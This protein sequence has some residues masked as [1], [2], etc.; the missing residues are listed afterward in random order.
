[1]H[2]WCLYFTF[3]R[4][5]LNCA[6]G[7]SIS[8]TTRDSFFI[9]MSKYEPCQWKFEPCQILAGI[10]CWPTA[11]CVCSDSQTPP[12]PQESPS[13][14]Q[15]SLWGPCHFGWIGT[16][17][18]LLKWLPRPWWADACFPL[19]WVDMIHS[20]SLLAVGS[21]PMNRWENFTPSST[22]RNCTVRK[23]TF[24]LELQDTDKTAVKL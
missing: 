18:Q 1:M 13:R 7:V 9:P 23:C 14:V 19:N 12:P 21:R 3:Q 10:S 5:N 22:V 15:Q 8:G 11:A 2:L 4:Q 6:L 24:K 20:D 17:D 16:E